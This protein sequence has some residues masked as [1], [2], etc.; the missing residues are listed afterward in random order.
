MIMKIRLIALSFGLLMITPN[1]AN[2]CSCVG[3]PTI[4]G[5]FASADAVFIG[6]G[7]KAER[8]EPKKNDE[9]SE[10]FSGQIAHVQVE[11][12]F[13]GEDMSEAIFHAGLTSCD[14][15]YKEGQ[16]WLFY[17]FY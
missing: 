14:P 8:R 12:V 5:A 3:D 11:R 17:A 2:G 13:K 15:I 9:R 6:S 4:C 1:V 10:I 7:R 16:R